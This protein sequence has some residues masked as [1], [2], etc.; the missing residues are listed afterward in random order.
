MIDNI[1]YMEI[2]G[3]KFPI[4]YTLNVMEQIQEEFGSLDDWIEAMEHLKKD[5]DGNVE[6][7]EDGNVKKEPKIKNLIWTFT[8]F[9]N[10]GIDIENEDAIE[11]RE[12]LTHKQVGRIITRLGI[13]K[14]TETI[15]TLVVANADT[16]EKNLS[17]TQSE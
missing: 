7:D 6:K 4:A 5:K 10:E 1:K 12:K 2:D 14:S 16:E 3:E 17:A 9:M 15:K 11:K 8:A 13:E